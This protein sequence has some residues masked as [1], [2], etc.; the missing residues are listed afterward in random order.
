MTRQ[1]LHP[2]HCALCHLH[3]HNQKHSFCFNFTHSH[4]LTRVVTHIHASFSVDLKN[5]KKEKNIPVRTQR[6]WVYKQ[7]TRKKSEMTMTLWLALLVLGV[8]VVR[9]EERPFV[10]CFKEIVAKTQSCE[11]KN[12]LYVSTMGISSGFGSEFN[13]YLVWSLI[14]AIFQNRFLIHLSI[15]HFYTCLR[16]Q[17]LLHSPSIT[18]T[19]AYYQLHTYSPTYSINHLLTRPL[20]RRLVYVIS[21]R[22]WEYDCPHKHGWGCYLD[23]KT[24]CSDGIVASNQL[25]FSNM[26]TYDYLT[27]GAGN[28]FLERNALLGPFNVPDIRCSRN[29]LYF[30]SIHSFFIHEGI[31]LPRY[32]RSTTRDHRNR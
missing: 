6:V 32:R 11:N 9:G 1:D 20:I 25:D 31:H 4:A 10:K 14:T 19:L 2:R 30:L 13:T 26:P 23:F 27:A 8:H 12:L 24:Q 29:Y 28:G 17:S 16:P 7:K 21:N 3:R 5:K 15:N 22:N 18:L